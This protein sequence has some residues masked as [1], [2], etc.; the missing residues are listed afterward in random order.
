MLTLLAISIVYLTYVIPLMLYNDQPG[1]RAATGGAIILVIMQYFWVFLLGMS[2]ESRL[3]RMFY[4]GGSGGGFSGGHTGAGIMQSNWSSAIRPQNKE[5]PLPTVQ[6]NTT[7][8]AGGAAPPTPAQK[9]SQFETA[10][11]LHSYQAN[12]EDP[13]ELSFGKDEMLEILDRK[14]NWWQARKEDGT[15]GIVPS[16]Y[17]SS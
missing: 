4:G 2:E 9:N 7:A 5:A 15:V 8:G 16:N 13:N 14:G 11:A 17:F 3:Y 12:P 6:Q 10:T 1:A